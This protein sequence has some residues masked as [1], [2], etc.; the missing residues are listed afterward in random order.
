MINKV[1][2]TNIAR[3]Y[4]EVD[5]ILEKMDKA[6]VEK[7]PIKLR[8]M[9]KEEKDVEY[10]NKIDIYDKVQ[11]KE[12]EPKTLTLLAMLYLNYWCKDDEEKNNLIKQY[13]END[14]KSEEETRE[15]YNPNNLF[16]NKEK[17]KEQIANNSTETSLIIVEK[18]KWYKK[19]FNFIKKFIKK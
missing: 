12:L 1:E 11:R 14:R 16:K 4:S 17:N 13:A 7:I 3:A 6:N 15:K 10:Q 19:I 18:E 8:K 2:Q 5:A 9:F